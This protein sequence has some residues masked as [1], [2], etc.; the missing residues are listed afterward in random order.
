MTCRVGGKHD[1]SKRYIQ[2]V[3]TNAWT[4]GLCDKP[5]WSLHYSYCSRCGKVLL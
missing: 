4:E 1:W 5:V 2:V 3:L